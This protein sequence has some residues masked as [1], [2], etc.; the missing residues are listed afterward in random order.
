MVE[1]MAMLE[2]GAIVGVKSQAFEVQGIGQGPVHGL[3]AG[4]ALCQVSR[5]QSFT[6]ARL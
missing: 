2:A 6:R 5:A 3:A 4:N 1:E